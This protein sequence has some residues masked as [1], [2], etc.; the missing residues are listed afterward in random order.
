M[1]PVLQPQ[2][3]S[4]EAV[5]TRL[6]EDP[7]A[8]RAMVPAGAHRYQVGR[9]EDAPDV[10]E[11]W[12]TPER[13]RRV[14]RLPANPSLL[15]RAV[16][17]R[18]TM[19]QALESA[20]VLAA[21]LDTSVER[22]VWR[23]GSWS[24][25]APAVHPS[26]LRPE[27]PWPVGPWT[28][29]GQWVAALEASQ[30]PARSALTALLRIGVGFDACHD[31]VVSLFLPDSAPPSFFVRDH[32]EVMRPL[33]VSLLQAC[34]AGRRDAVRWALGQGADAEA[35]Y[36]P[37]LVAAL[38]APAPHRRE[39]LALLLE[40]AD[41][42][43]VGWAPLPF[44]AVIRGALDD[45]LATGLSIDT[46]DRRG[47]TALHM[48]VGQRQVAVVR[49]LLAA[50]AD[51]DHRDLRGWT[52]LHLALHLG[53][54]EAREVLVAGGARSLPDRAGV[55][56]LEPW[57]RP[58]PP[59]RSHLP[60]PAV[61]AAS[62]PVFADWLEEQGDS[63]AP[64]VQRSL[65]GEQVPALEAE[66][67]RR[68]S[69]L[70]P[71]LA[72]HLFEVVRLRHGFAVEAH[73]LEP[74]QDPGVRQLLLHPEGA[75]LE[76]ATLCTAAPIPLPSLLHDLTLRLDAPSEVRLEPGALESL[77]VRGCRALQLHAPTLRRLAVRLPLTRERPCNPLLQLHAPRL[78]VLDLELPWVPDPSAAASLWRVLDGLPLWKL[79]LQ[80]VDVASIDRLAA[81]PLLPR[82]RVL[83]LRSLRREGVERLIEA[84][85][86]FAHLE[87]KV[88]VLSTPGNQRDAL[89]QLLVAWIP[90][91]SL[92]GESYRQDGAYANR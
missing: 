39:V 53:D 1:F 34:R 84:P 61:A 8:V 81:S 35:G 71:A 79:A 49:V 23:L 64:W 82:L 54:A 3:E 56:A 2:G 42:E 6:R 12:V 90:G 92:Q 51:P 16:A 59:A 9:R 72:A 74:P 33:Q 66:G 24:V 85:E 7:D 26:S 58:S 11:L 13:R 48:A 89:S 88:S 20:A 57:A 91:A 76:R 80:P 86:P 17:F 41:P 70:H 83:E 67:R 19:G 10:E 68:I 73:A 75:R 28:R 78:G 43:N 29:L 36:P 63:R 60:T 69:A 44:H 50:G 25:N 14:S 27:A 55:G 40:H 21:R 15:V 45:L 62:W 22:V 46:P 87:L 37:A 18:A 5:R 4:L 32:P 52:P 38:D 30:D 31:G 77:T 47:R 65:A